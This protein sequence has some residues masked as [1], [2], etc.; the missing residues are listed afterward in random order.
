MSKFLKIVTL[1]ATGLILSILLFVNDLFDLSHNEV[2]KIPQVTE[3]NI[4]ET[5]ETVTDIDGNIYKT[6]KIG[7]QVWMAENLKTINYNDGEPIPLV[8]SDYAWGNLETPGYCWMNNDETN[9]DSY[10]AL[11]N[12]Y[13]V[14]T[15][16]VAPKGWH[17]PTEEE[18]AT[19]IEFVG[20][21]RDSGGML[22]EKGTLHWLA[23]NNGA[24]D[25]YGFSARA[26]GYRNYD[27]LVF[28]QP[29]DGGYFWTSTEEE[30]STAYGYSMN[31][32][33]IDVKKW[34]VSKTY[35]RSIRCIKDGPLNDSS[36]K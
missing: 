18:W 19:L 36:G 2:S 27:G 29:L 32:D 34:G 5:E 9:K 28:L 31:F 21:E 12:W 7:T 13:V 3:T 1:L 16:K 24:S 26:G 25:T 15:D 17:V 20:S 10:G 6:I 33:G 30:V 23:P 22:K 8:E 35:G 11:Y 4:S 14:D